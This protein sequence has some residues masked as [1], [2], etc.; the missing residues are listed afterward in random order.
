MSRQERAKRLAFL[1]P[2]EKSRPIYASK[3][4]FSTVVSPT[5]PP[6][7]PL[8][9]PLS[10]E[11]TITPLTPQQSATTTSLS[12]A[13]E[14]KSPKPSPLSSQPRFQRKQNRTK[15]ATNHV[16]GAVE[17]CPPHPSLAKWRCHICGKRYAIGVTR[18]CLK[19]GHSLC[20][21]VLVHKP[22]LNSK[23]TQEQPRVV[24]DKVAKEEGRNE[25]AKAI[26]AQRQKIKER[27]RLS[28]RANMVT[29]G[30]AVKFDFDGWR[31]FGA[32]KRRRKTGMGASCENGCDWPGECRE[33]KIR[34]AARMKGANA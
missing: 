3:L 18:R 32:W 31:K 6:L 29:K 30:C 21:P 28:M 27:N 25:K 5:L 19:D 23:P 22:Q 11:S 20:F 17:T 10:F 4:R 16:V 2:H 15:R 9:S 12:C 13:V 26:I 24:N 34:A 7:P 14:N 8:I 1:Q 33:R